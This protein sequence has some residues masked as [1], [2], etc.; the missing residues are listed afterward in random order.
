[1]AQRVGAEQCA[2]I[3]KRLWCLGGYSAQE[4]NRKNPGAMQ[5]PVRERKAFA[6]EAKRL[7]R[8]DAQ[9]WLDADTIVAYGPVELK[10]DAHSYVGCIR[11]SNNTR[12]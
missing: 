5:M 8:L 4:S 11:K 9:K 3:V 10:P 6:A 1:M 12:N 2:S 7:A